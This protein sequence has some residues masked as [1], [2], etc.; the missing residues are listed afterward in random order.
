MIIQDEQD[1]CAKPT[2]SNLS[3]PLPYKSETQT[4]HREEIKMRQAGRRENV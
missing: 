3:G 2:Y 1:F 4:V